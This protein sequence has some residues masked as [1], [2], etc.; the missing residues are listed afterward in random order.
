[1]NHR[2]RQIRFTRQLRNK[3]KQHIVRDIIVA[4]FRCKSVNDSKFPIFIYPGDNKVVVVCRQNTVRNHDDPGIQR[5]SENHDQ[6]NL[7]GILFD[8]MKYG[9]IQRRYVIS[10]VWFFHIRFF[11]FPLAVI[12]VLKCIRCYF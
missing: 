11:I 10:F 6:A 9:F 4:N 3:G 5:D 2:K 1:M 8:K 12:Y 7:E